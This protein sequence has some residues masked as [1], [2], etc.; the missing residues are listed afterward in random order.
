MALDENVARLELIGATEWIEA[1]RE[2]EDKFREIYEKKI[3][4]EGDVDVPTVLKSRRKLIRHLT[5]C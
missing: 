3:A 5:D 2:K 1:L 4:A